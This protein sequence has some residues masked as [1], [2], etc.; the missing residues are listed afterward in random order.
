MGYERKDQILEL[1]TYQSVF[2]MKIRHAL[3]LNW[4]LL[5]VLGVH[6]PCMIMKD[7]EIASSLFIFFSFLFVF[8]FLLLVLQF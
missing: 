7:L 2:V 4:S 6:D 5:F 8:F 1:G 3:H